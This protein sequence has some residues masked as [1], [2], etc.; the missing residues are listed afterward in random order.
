MAS[1]NRTPAT[2]PICKTAIL[3][4]VAGDGGWA[5]K[6]DQKLQGWFIHPDDIQVCRKEDG[7]EWLLVCQ[8]N[9]STW[10]EHTPS[11]KMTPPAGWHYPWD[12]TPLMGRRCASAQG[13][14]AYGRVYRGLRG[15]VQDVAVKQ[16]LHT[17]DGQMGEFVKVQRFRCP[18][19]GQQSAGLHQCSSGKVRWCHRTASHRSGGTA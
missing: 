1:S 5:S 11:C 16:L 18:R 10:S 6:F 8:H 4:P 12:N 14:G 17:G 13:E 3:Y 2:Q 7:T 9:A 19:K 15:G